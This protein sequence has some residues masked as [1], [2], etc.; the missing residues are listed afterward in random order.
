MR[1]LPLLSINDLTMVYKTRK[2]F[3]SAIDGVSFDLNKGETMGLVG[4]SGC[5]KTSIAMT[6]LKLTPDN[7]I[8]QKG[9]ILLDGEDL[10][11]MSNGHIQ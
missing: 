4:E 6:L 2:G 5:G 9:Q 10:V 1:E 8:I 7:A 11:P 3:V